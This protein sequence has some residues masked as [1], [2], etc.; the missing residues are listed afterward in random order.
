MLAILPFVVAAFEIWL[1]VGDDRDEEEFEEFVLER[2]CWEMATEVL[3]MLAEWD[4]VDREAIVPQAWWCCSQSL[5]WQYDPQYLATLQPPQV[6]FAFLPQFQ[7]DCC[8]TE[9]RGEGMRTL[10]V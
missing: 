9:D 10:W 2:V 3:M 4:S 5:C 8:Q 6:S 7:H 1:F